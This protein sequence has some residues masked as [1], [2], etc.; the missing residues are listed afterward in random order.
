MYRKNVATDIKFILWEMDFTFWNSKFNLLCKSG[1]I[2]IKHANPLELRC[3]W[4]YFWTNKYGWISLYASVSKKAKTM[5][6][7]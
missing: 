5:Q 1:G 6:K 2:L 7:Y 3:Q 4:A